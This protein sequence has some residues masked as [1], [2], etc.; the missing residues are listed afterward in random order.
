MI[1]YRHGRNLSPDHCTCVLITVHSNLIRISVINFPRCTQSMARGTL[2]YKHQLSILTRHQT[3]VCLSIALNYFFQPLIS[4]KILAQGP[5]AGGDDPML[6]GSVTCIRRHHYMPNIATMPTR[7]CISVCSI[8]LFMQTILLWTWG[9]REKRGAVF[10]SFCWLAEIRNGDLYS[11]QWVAVV[12]YI[13]RIF[14]FLI[15]SLIY[16][17]GTGQRSVTP[18][19]QPLTFLFL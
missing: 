7:D 5:V 2:T 14:F 6:A 18:I 15:L 16:K 4:D 9:T 13:V 19:V 1:H 11:Y 10:C 8:S 3:V 12:F 17:R